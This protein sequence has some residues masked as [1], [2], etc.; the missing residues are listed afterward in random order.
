MDVVEWFNY[1]TFDIIGDLGW[2]SSF[3]CLKSQ[4]ISGWIQVVLHFKAVVIAASFKYFP[5]LDSILEAI[6][7]KEALKDIN[8]VVDTA[9]QRVQNVSP[10]RPTG[11]IC[12]ATYRKVQK[13]WR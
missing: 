10:K 9:R 13:G 11:Q 3:D 8:M 4:K 6:T 1:A 2:G 7:P 12:L 5:P